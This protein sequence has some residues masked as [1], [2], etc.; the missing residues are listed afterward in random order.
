MT[1][2]LISVLYVSEAVQE[3]DVPALKELAQFASSK[4]EEFGITGYLYFEKRRFL[5][6]IEGP[7]EHIDQ[8]VTNIAGDERHKILHQ[9]GEPEVANRRFPT[10]SMQYLTKTSLIEIK[11]QDVIFDYMRF[12]GREDPGY[13]SSTET[14]VW[15]MVEKLSENHQRMVF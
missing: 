5:Q 3:F 2:P 13:Q 8:L 15:N 10:W 12:I 9:V 4:N 6:Y 11:M 7:K 14:L 1:S